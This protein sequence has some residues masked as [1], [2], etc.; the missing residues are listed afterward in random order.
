MSQL[1]AHWWYDLAGQLSHF[2]NIFRPGCHAPNQGSGEL[3]IAA[4]GSRF[5]QSARVLDHERRWLDGYFDFA[6][7]LH[8]F[9]FWI[10][11]SNKEDFSSFFR[12]NSRVN[13]S[14]R[15]FRQRVR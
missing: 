1:V 14:D 15:R 6:G 5:A 9:G 10:Q 4:I 13:L 12:Q 2:C 11:N 7:T 8:L 3:A